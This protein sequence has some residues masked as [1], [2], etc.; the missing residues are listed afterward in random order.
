MSFGC[1][2]AITV[3]FLLT[4]MSCLA[5]PVLDQ[6]YDQQEFGGGGAGSVVRADYRIGQSFT[7]GQSGGLAQVGV[8]V[9]NLTS[10]GPLEMSVYAVDDA[11]YPNFTQLMTALIGGVQI[12]YANRH[13][14]T[15]DFS[16][17]NLQVV[18]GQ[19]YAFFLRALDAGSYAVAGGN[20]YEDGL[21]FNGPGYLGGAAWQNNSPWANSYQGRNY[22]IDLNF[23]TYVVPMA[24]DAPSSLLLVLAL[25]MLGL[26][27]RKTV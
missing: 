13:Y 26:R 5:T 16:T 2:L 8:E 19:A 4:A 9:W 11:G 24:I 27:W 10:T 12:G 21:T 7:V 22:S 14:H 20:H 3:I 25:T 17:F 6:Y 15:A 1:R 18:A 23:R